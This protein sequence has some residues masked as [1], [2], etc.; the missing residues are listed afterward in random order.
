MM[1]AFVFTSY[2]AQAQFSFGVRA[3]FNMTKVSVNNN[4]EASRKFLPGFQVGF[5]G[6]I[7]IVPAF[8]I[9]PA[10]LF[11]THGWSVKDGNR[12]GTVGYN[13]I[14]VPVNLQYKVELGGPKLLV[15]AGPYFGY[16]LGGK[17]K[18]DGKTEKIT[19]GGSDSELKAVDYGIT[20]G[21][22]VQFGR[23]Q[24]G[25]NYLLGLADI[26]NTANF[27]ASVKNTGLSLTL[28]YLF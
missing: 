6:D 18:M 17:Y 20:G 24:I 1:M 9:Q 2:Y 3:G 14:Q 11:S 28:T 21:A 15:Q 27:G 5:V 26:V 25:V 22:G 19:M 8:A 16:G 10:V 13:Y 4:V 23:V 12:V 7:S